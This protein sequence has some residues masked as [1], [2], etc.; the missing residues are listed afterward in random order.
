MVNE[1]RKKMTEIPLRGTYEFDDYIR[2]RH[3]EVNVVDDSFHLLFIEKV[4]DTG[5][6]SVCFGAF[7]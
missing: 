3:F 1:K 4:D 7:Q 2:V 5:P 6:E